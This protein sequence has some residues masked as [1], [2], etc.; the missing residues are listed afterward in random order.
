M[1]SSFTQIQQVMYASTV[2]KSVL[3]IHEF[4]LFPQFCLTSQ[5]IFFVTYLSLVKAKKFYLQIGW[6][7]QFHLWIFPRVKL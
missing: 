4:Y 7:Y 6:V 2:S 5:F 1:Q 3:Y